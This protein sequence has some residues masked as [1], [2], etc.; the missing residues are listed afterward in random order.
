MTTHGTKETRAVPPPQTPL[1]AGSDSD[2][3]YAA[4]RSR[5]VRFDGRFFTGVKTTGIYCRPICP[6]RTPLRKNVEFF[7]CAAAAESAGFRPCLRCRPDAAPGS[8]EWRGTSS[9]VARGL[10]LIADGALDESSVEELASRL[11][12]GE[13]H[14]HRLFVRHLG[15]AP[16]AVA[17]THRAHMARHLLEETDGTSTEIAFAAGFSSVRRFHTVFRR[18][19]G[20]SPK[21]MRGRSRAN[22]NDDAPAIRLTLRPRLPFDW[23]ALLSFLGPRC[24]PLFEEVDG[25]TFRRRTQVDGTDGWIEVAPTD[26]L[27]NVLELRTAHPV[28]RELL[29]LVERARDV[30]DLD[31]D[32][33]RIAEVLGGDERLA[34][35]LETHGPARVPGAWDGFELAMRAILGQQVT[36]AGARTLAGR[37][38]ERA[39]ALRPE[40]IVRADLTALGVPTKRAET[41]QQLSRRVLDGKLYL[42]PWTDPQTAREE[43]LSIPGIGPWTVEYIAMRAL[44]DPDAFPASDLGIRKA[45]GKD[46][47]PCS[48]KDAERWA[49]AWR[50]W[51]SYAVMLLW[52]SL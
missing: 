30:F 38:A 5:D 41:L 43:L 52:R 29:R 3:Y 26:P 46:G 8:P 23:D 7:T 34:S 19:F 25:R 42:D 10:R 1:P 21:E 16:V 22:R 13:R 11:G 15:A 50:P 37:L 47:E 45:L 2:V 33:L 20:V 14:L 44:R 4:I 24:L 27:G 32:T 6:A 49:D 18:T 31:A 9:T 40:A 39:G 35:L 17:Q 36:V 12:V 28:S 48:A 51:R